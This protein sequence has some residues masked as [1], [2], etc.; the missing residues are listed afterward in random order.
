MASLDE[1]IGR[2]DPNDIDAILAITNTD[3][4]EAVHEVANHADTVYTWN[5]EKGARPAL[6]KLYEK[7]KAGQWN[8]ETDLPWDTV[9][10]P[11]E[12]AKAAFEATGGMD[13]LIDFTGTPVAKVGPCRVDR[14]QPPGPGLDAE[15]VPPR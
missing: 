13:T 10:D 6:A 12:E 11:Y 9:V 4:A 15:P 5:Y 7:A 1:I 2:T 3:A 8:G 14:V